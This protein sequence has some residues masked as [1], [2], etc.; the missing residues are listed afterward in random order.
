ML[1]KQV[2]PGL[3]SLVEAMQRYTV[4]GLVLPAKPAL[5]VCLT[6]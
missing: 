6:T 2:T 1:E 5:E 4:P 3:A